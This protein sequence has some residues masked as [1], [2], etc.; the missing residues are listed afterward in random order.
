[1]T[2]VPPDPVVA[3]NGARPC[4]HPFIVDGVVVARCDLWVFPRSRW[5]RRTIHA[6]KRH[7]F[8]W[9]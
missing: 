9:W 2:G 1:M 3:E 7:R 6:G 5:W 8:T 4:N